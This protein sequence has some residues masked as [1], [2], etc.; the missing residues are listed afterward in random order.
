MLFFL[1][2]NLLKLR[3]AIHPIFGPGSDSYKN[4]PK[5]SGLIRGLR[6]FGLKILAIFIKVFYV[7][8]EKKICPYSGHFLTLT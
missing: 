4:P 6:I 2:E 5:K 1:G 8:M 7:G 3:L